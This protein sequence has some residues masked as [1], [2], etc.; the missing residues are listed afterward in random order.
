MK[1]IKE[2]QHLSPQDISR[3]LDAAGY[4]V[5][6]N[7]IRKVFAEGSENH[8]FRF[9][10]TIQ[11][12]S[13]VLLGIYGSDTEDSEIEGL[14][15]AIRVKDELIQKLERELADV[16][17]DSARRSTF[18]MNQIDLKDQRIDKL[19]SRVDEVL[20]SNRDLLQQLQRL[21]EKLT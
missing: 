6:E 17:T 11:P 18:L 21:L 1:A 12:I 7:S 14:K 19:M 2:E 8:N 15:A 3:M 4:H 16:K 10:D 13:R 9:H 20:S 5:S